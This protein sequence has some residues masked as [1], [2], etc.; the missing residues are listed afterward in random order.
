MTFASD[1]A[2]ATV[3]YVAE[4]L[5][6]VVRPVEVAETMSNK[7]NFRRFQHAHHLT[8]PDFA[9]ID[10][11]ADLDGALLALTPPLI[12][13]PVDTSGSRGITKV[14]AIDGAACQLAYHTARNF[15]RSGVV[16]VETFVCG[17]MSV[18]MAFCWTGGCVRL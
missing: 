3:A 11:L 12:F 9:I 6:L 16:S 17:L 10:R 4:H 15:A 2:T 1:V 7:A 8:C 5:G 18:A 13:K 14:D